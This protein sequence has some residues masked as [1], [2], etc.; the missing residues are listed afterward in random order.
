MREAL[1]ADAAE[2]IE[3]WR[4][5][6]GDSF[7]T[8]K[9]E[10][11]LAASARVETYEKRAAPGEQWIDHDYGIPVRLDSR[12]RFRVVGR[13]TATA[14]AR[15]RLRPLAASGNHVRVGRDLSFTV[16]G[17]T[18]PEPFDVYW[19]VRNA[20]EEAAKLKNFRGEIRKE[21]LRITERSNFPGNHW[22][23]AW[24]VKE[25]VAVATDVQDVTIVAR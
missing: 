2:S 19:K 5:V 18:V 8:E 7:G 14:R 11:A 23:Q 21:G 15:G 6:F 1:D 16:E 20:G 3:K 10:N 22:V 17:C 4:A 25:G 24:I 9:A 13:A 12:Y